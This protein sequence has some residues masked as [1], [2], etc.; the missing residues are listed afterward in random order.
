MA[1]QAGQS[2][3]IVVDQA[4]E[5]LKEAARSNIA[6]IQ[7]ITRRMRLLALNAQI[8]AAHAGQTGFA[9]VAEEVKGVA[10]EIETLAAGLGGDVGARVDDL[11]NAVAGLASAARGDRFVDLALN[12]VEIIDRNL[13]ERTCDVRWWATDSAVVDC[14]A[15]PRPEAVAH[16]ERRLGVILS[17]YTVYLDLWLC[18][19]NGRVIA[20][21]RP[22]RFTARG[23]DASRT[24][25]FAKAKSLASGDDFAVAE[26]D[27]CAELG[28]AQVAT[29][30]ASVREDGAPHGK[31][32]GFLAIHFDWEPQARSIVEGV[33]L[34]AE[35]AA[36]S[37]VLLLDAGHRVIA[38]T[39]GAA[40]GEAFPLA[41]G[42]RDSGLYADNSGRL[43]A[44]HKTP[45]YETYRGMGWFGVIEYAPVAARASAP[46]PSR[47]ERAWGPASAAVV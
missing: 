42:G 13:Y 9:V 35:E 37:R 21:G 26:I 6:A 11:R 36:Q 14:A 30:V 22:Q 25:W 38:G 31:P 7:N 32:L 19:L 28:G 17:A 16:A 41:T 33:R 40:L 27:R 44:F 18:D 5:S 1:T 34:T 3:G 29:Y 10:R 12:A 47:P 39:R 15:A 43:I 45:G 8:E 20:N 2:L 4:A 23:A 24:R 46:A